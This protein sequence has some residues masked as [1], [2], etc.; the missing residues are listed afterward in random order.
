MRRTVGLNHIHRSEDVSLV[1]RL[2]GVFIPSPEC[3]HE[4]PGQPAATVE[5]FLRQ[6]E[7]IRDHTEEG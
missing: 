4:V 6:A 7:L 3:V 1:K 2:P 5:L